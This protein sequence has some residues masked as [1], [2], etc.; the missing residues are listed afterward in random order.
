MRPLLLGC[1]T[2]LALSVS[3]T[4]VKNPVYAVRQTGLTFTPFK[5]TLASTDADTTT[6]KLTF[7]CATAVAANM[8]IGSQQNNFCGASP[9]QGNASALNAALTSIPIVTNATAN[10]TASIRFVLLDQGGAQL[11]SKT[12]NFVTLS[13]IPL[14]N[15]VSNLEVGQ[16][17]EDANTTASFVIGNID[18]DYCN[19]FG[20]SGLKLTST[21]TSPLYTVS[22]TDCQVSLVVLDVTKVTPSSLSLTITDSVSGLQTNRWDV[23]VMPAVGNGTS[24]SRA[25]FWVFV[26]ISTIIIGCF[27]MM[28]CYANSKANEYDKAR[29]ESADVRYPHPDDLRN[30]TIEIKPN[31]LSDSILTWNKQLM[32]KYQQK[33]LVT[34]TNFEKNT[35]KILRNP[36]SASKEEVALV[37]METKEDRPVRPF[38]DISEIGTVDFHKSMNMEPYR[39]DDS[40]F[41]E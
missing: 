38:E 3:F 8:Q 32:A 19:F 18:P 16:S 39:K 27:M 22:M 23:I 28:L 5:V 24:L 33:S 25:D 15:Q 13:A 26:M 20:S 35:E 36:G 41:D 10:A 6:Y 1:L 7:D 31:V 2:G 11:A 37:Q 30:Q 40:F 4:D 14:S 9:L 12:I 34:S 21:P 29:A 17:V